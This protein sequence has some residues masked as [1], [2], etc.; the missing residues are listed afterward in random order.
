MGLF[1][2]IF[3]PTKEEQIHSLGMLLKLHEEQ[4]GYCTTCKNYI[5]SDM[6]GFV[7][8]F[9]ECKKRYSE[10]AQKV[11]GMIDCCPLYEED[12]EKMVEIKQIIHRISQSRRATSPCC[13][14]PD[15][16]AGDITERAAGCGGVSGQV[17]A[18]AGVSQMKKTTLCWRCR[19]AVP[20]RNAG[21]SWSRSFRPVPGWKAKRCKLRMCK[22]GKA[23]RFTFSYDVR[24]CPEFEEG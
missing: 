5:S 8:D 13:Q 4:I 20:S 15:Q 9:G 1:M 22:A 17:P 14:R 18:E 12:V 21:C 11:C 7:T 3:N 24:K 16:N 6:P 23:P 10:F 19:N 2:R